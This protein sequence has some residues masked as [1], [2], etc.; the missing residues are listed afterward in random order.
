LLFDDR[1]QDIELTVKQEK[2]KTK[3]QEKTVIELIPL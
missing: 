2:V 3:A 1:P